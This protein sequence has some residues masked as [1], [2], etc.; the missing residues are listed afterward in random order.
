MLLRK[1]RHLRLHNT[2][3]WCGLLAS[4]P[5]NMATCFLDVATKTT[6]GVAACSENGKES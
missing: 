4:G 3:S 6:S 1:A 5:L 2:R